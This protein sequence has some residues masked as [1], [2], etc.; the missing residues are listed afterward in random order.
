MIAA[1]KLGLSAFFFFYM[2]APSMEYDFC[3]VFLPEGL[4]ALVS[5]STL[6][7]TFEFR[8]NPITKL[9]VNPRIEVISMIKPSTGLGVMTLSIA[10]TTS[11]AVNAQ[12][13]S[14]LVRAPN[15]SALEYPYERLVFLAGRRPIQIEKIDITKPETSESR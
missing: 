15:I 7:Q 9:Q 4:L 5:T 1:F 8:K 12:I 13:M 14:T 11:Q 6:P 10:S 3:N 2:A